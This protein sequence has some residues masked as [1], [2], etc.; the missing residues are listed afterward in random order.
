M[1]NNAIHSYAEMPATVPVQVYLD[2]YVG[3]TVQYKFVEIAPDYKGRIPPGYDLVEVSGDRFWE[4]M[5]LF[6]FD[7]MRPRPRYRHGF[8]R[9]V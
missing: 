8:L 1:S 7:E 5:V 6:G 3:D 9:L 2:P 4:A